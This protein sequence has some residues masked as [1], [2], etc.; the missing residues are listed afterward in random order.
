LQIE[1]TSS[2][3][4]ATSNISF[5]S[6]TSSL[7]SASESRTGDQ[8]NYVYREVV[9][10]HKALGSIEDH[11]RLRPDGEQNSVMSKTKA[12]KIAELFKDAADALNNL[13]DDRKIQ[14]S[15]NSDLQ[16]FVSNIRSNL[17]SAVSEAFGSAGNPLQTD[18]GI[19]FEFN[20]SARRVCDFSYLDQN[21]LVRKLTTNGSP[22]NELFYGK[23]IKDND[24]LLE[25]MLES[26]KSAKSDLK[27]ILGTSGVFVD[28]KA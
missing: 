3:S 28:T 27:D 20:V 1:G 19:T 15:S 10:L 22:V 24:G 26:L 18:Y 12:G 25:K 21:K 6:V 14:A 8:L 9:K 7:S 13:F 5:G 23:K 4:G 16:K 11:F 2:S 17:E